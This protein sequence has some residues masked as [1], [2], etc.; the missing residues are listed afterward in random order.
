LTTK[1]VKRHDSGKAKFAD[2][3]VGENNRSDYFDRDRGG[4]CKVSAEQERWMEVI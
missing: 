2:G 4:V 3:L 1:I